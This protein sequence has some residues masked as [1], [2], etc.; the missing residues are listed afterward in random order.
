MKRLTAAAAS[1]LVAGS[2]VALSAGA[3]NAVTH[4]VTSKHGEDK[5]PTAR[6]EDNAPPVR[7]EDNTPG[8]CG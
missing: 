6:G 7:G 5:A 4:P 1:M 8:A 2:F 3:A